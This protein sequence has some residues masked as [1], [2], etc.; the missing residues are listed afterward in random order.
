MYT[1]TDKLDYFKTEYFGSSKD[2]V[3]ESKCKPTAGKDNYN[4]YTH[5]KVLIC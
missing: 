3:R 2:T 1:T 4:V 5:I